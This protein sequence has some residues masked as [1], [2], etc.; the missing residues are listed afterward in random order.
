MQSCEDVLSCTINKEINLEDGLYRMGL[1]AVSELDPDLSNAL[2][3]CT[4][5]LEKMNQSTSKWQTSDV[6]YFVVAVVYD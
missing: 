3:F 2:G 6:V 5:I 4:V 1:N